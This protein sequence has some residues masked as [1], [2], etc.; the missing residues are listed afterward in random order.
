[1]E[2]SRIRG[3]VARGRSLARGGEQPGGEA[4]SR[5]TRPAGSPER[6]KTANGERAGGNPRHIKRE[7][8]G[9]RPN[10]RA[11]GRTRAKA[12]SAAAG[13]RARRSKGDEVDGGQGGRTEGRA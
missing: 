8:E 3:N 2:E 13:G 9:Q 1:M 10:Q 7:A 11:Q 4:A 6:T 5:A 12:E